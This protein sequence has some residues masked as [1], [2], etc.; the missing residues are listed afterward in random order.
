MDGLTET[1]QSPKKSRPELSSTSAN[2]AK[3]D[4]V[5]NAQATEQVKKLKSRSKAKKCMTVSQS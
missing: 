5:E 4:K 3:F 2:E 1:S